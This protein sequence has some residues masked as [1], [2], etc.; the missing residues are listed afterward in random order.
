M[1]SGDKGLVARKTAQ[2]IFTF[3]G[4]TADLDLDDILAAVDFLDTTFDTDMDLL[5][6]GVTIGEYIAANLPEPFNS[7]TSNQ[8]KAIL[9]AVFEMV[10]GGLGSALP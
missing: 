5:A 2:F 8:E 7:S 10:A 3:L 1:G 6:S 4:A 9:L